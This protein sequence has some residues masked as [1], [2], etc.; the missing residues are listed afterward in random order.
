MADIFYNFPA[1]FRD[2]DDHVDDGGWKEARDGGDQALSD[3]GDQPTEKSAGEMARYA[4]SLLKCSEISN[5]HR[6]GSRKGQPYLD[7]NPTNLHVESLSFE[8]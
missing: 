6:S 5:I 2:G 1:E 8:H 3:G 7:F 4:L